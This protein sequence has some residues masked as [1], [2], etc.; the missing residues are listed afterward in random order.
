MP[1]LNFVKRARTD[2]Y[3]NGR[4]VKANNKQGYTI[5]YSKPEDI[6]DELI[7]HKGESYYWWQFAYGPK[8]FSK[9]RPDKRRLTRSEFQLGLYDIEDEINDINADMELSDIEERVD[10]IKDMIEELRDEQEDKKSNMPDQLQESETGELLQE[11]YDSLD[12]AYDEFSGLDFYWDE[13][14]D[15]TLEEFIEN[16][17]SEIQGI[18][19]S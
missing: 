16:L 3:R 7:C 2:R 11:R 9:E 1:R 18:C 4:K 15:E 13:S 12:Q 10:S 6:S 17:I 8:Q 19:L 14:S 5:D